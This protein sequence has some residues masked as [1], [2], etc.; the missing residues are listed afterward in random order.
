MSRI[1]SAFTLVEVVVVLVAI[2]VVA[3]IGIA[4]YQG[5]MSRAASAKVEAAAVSVDYEMRAAMTFGDRLNSAY[6]AVLPSVPA[7]ISVTF[8]D[9]DGNDKLD[10]GE[11]IV[12]SSVDA[13]LQMHIAA[14]DDASAR[15]AASWHTP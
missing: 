10:S 2:S 7:D 5:V 4:T 15:W 14:D 11:T 9:A 3:A 12:V 6:T 8:I 13:P 1:R